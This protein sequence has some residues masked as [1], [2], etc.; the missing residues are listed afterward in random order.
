MSTTSHEK[1]PFQ[2]RYPNAPA[3]HPESVTPPPTPTKKG[4]FS[5]FESLPTLTIKDAFNKIIGDLSRKC[6]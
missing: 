3:E 6:S 1:E 5:E 2:E 4:P